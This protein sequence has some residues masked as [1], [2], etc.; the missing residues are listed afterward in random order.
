M[1]KKVTRCLIEQVAQDRVG[2]AGDSLRV[3]K[4]EDPEGGHEPDPGE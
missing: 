1:K 3:V 2:G 4:P